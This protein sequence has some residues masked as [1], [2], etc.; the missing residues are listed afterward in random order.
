MKRL[1]AAALGLAGAILNFAVPGHAQDYPAKAVRILAASPGATNDI[2]SRYLA[3]QL[4]ER[5][6]K[7]VFVENRPGAGG[8]IAAEHA[9]K[10]APDGYSLHIAYTA[11][12]AVSPTLY[13]KLGYDPV[14]DFAPIT[15][16]ADTPL[17]LL[18]HPSMPPRNLR[19]FIQFA[20]KH[21]G[22][23]NYS[24][25]SA[26]TLSHLVTELLK[27]AAGIKLVHVPY[28]GS[29]AATTALISGEAQFSSLV[30]PNALPMLRAGRVKAYAITGKK[31]FSGAP[32][33]P[34]AAEAGLPDFEATSWFGMCVP[35]RTPPSIIGRLN[36]DIVEILRAP[37]T[38]DWL[39]KQ[40]AEAIPSTPEAFGDL[41][42]SDIVKW[43][44]V[45][46]ASSARAD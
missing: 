6:G 34:T 23:I 40:G 17:M 21:P 8:T 14:R 29:G 28:K 37:A 1:L 19:E 43:K 13:K 33:V 2:L 10:A 44:K 20:K 45:V 3:Q 32:D 16:Y 7:Q 12:F 9:S 39:Y 36:R 15:L 38:R 42:R 11:T 5:W 4:S 31:R 41:I 46:E 22:A 30:L 25:A 18:A 35:A 27:D 24:S 26:G